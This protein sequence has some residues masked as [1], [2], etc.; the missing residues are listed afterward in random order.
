MFDDR[1]S[2]L[3]G[4]RATYVDTADPDHAVMG[5]TVGALL[6]V[7]RG[8]SVRQ[9]HYLDLDG[10]MIGRG[11]DVDVLLTDP[12][13]SRYHAHIA[14]VSG[15]YEILDQGSA[16]GTFVNRREVVGRAK[17]PD[18]CLLRFGP[19]TTVQFMA[20]DEQGARSIRSMQR[21]MFQ[22]PLTSLGNRRQLERRLRE[23]L[24]FG[25]RHDVAIG[26][27]FVDIDHFKRVNDRFGHA[28]GDRVLVEIG[29]LLREAVRGEDVVFRYGGE[30]FCVL[31]RNATELGL[32]IVAERLCMLVRGLSVPVEGGAVQITISVGGAFTR[33][34]DGPKACTWAGEE[35]DFELGEVEL[36]ARADQAMYHAKSAGR[37]RISIVRG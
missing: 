11:E 10:G 27:L 29:R 25:A 12:T 34:N 7:L 15:R 2:G 31:V 37:D 28:V 23:E 24:S 30:E 6:T 16:N 33:P 1:D 13:I 14:F 9:L 26:L 21:E 19:H 20:V 36:V 22:D 4:G 17:L 3:G 32:S 18:H 8:H 35:G 5:P